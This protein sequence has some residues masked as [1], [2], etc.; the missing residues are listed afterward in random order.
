L[1]ARAGGLKDTALD[2]IVDKLPKEQQLAAEKAATEWREEAG[3][4]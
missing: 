3:L 2:A 1:I 4:F